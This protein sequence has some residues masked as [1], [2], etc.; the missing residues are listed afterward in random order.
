MNEKLSL[1][2]SVSVIALVLYG[3]WFM[4]DFDRSELTQLSTTVKTL[5]DTLGRSPVKVQDENEKMILYTGAAI[6]LIAT[7]YTLTKSRGR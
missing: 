2:A 1:I 5:N 6:L 3:V 7:L 4:S